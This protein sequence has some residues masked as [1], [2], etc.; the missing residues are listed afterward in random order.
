M[1]IWYVWTFPQ[2]VEVLREWTIRNPLINQESTRN[3]PSRKTRLLQINQRRQ[4]CAYCNADNHINSSCS[5]IVE[6]RK[7]ILKE[8]KLRYNCTKKY[9]SATECR[10]KRSCN[11]CNQR[12][13]TLICNKK[14]KSVPTL[15]L[16]EKG[17]VIYP[18]VVVLINGIKC[19]LWC[20]KFLYFFDHCTLIEKT[21]S[22][23][24]NQMDRDDDE[25][26]N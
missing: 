12:H 11:N 17:N 23:E 5:K 14:M 2:L 7:K 13:H 8:K 18:V 3:Q 22:Q 9:H 15:N 10:S 6:E 16:S 4:K 19:R 20:R 26:S 1:Q 21:T 25:F 24:G